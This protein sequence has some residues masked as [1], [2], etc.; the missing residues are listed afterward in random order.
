MFEFSILFEAPES[1]DLEDRIDTKPLSL[2]AKDTHSDGDQLQFIGHNS[3]GSLNHL[4]R[5]RNE[6]CQE[7]CL[8]KGEFAIC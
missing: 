7:F 6:F 3:V 4:L 8:A 5:V 2:D 1:F